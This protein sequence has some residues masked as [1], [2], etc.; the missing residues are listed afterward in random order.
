MTTASDLKSELVGQVPQLDPYAALKFVSRAFRDVADVREWGFLR[1]RDVLQIPASVTT[2]TVSVTQFSDAVTFDGAAAAVLDV[3]NNPPVTRRQLRVGDG[4]AYNI[5]TYTP[6]GTAT[7]DRPYQEDTDASA[8]YTLLRCYY[9]APA[10]FLRFI[11]I[12]DPL[13]Q[14]YV[15]TGPEFTQIWLDRIDPART[16][17]G[18]PWVLCTAQAD[19]ATS[20]LG[21][22]TYE[23]WPWPTTAQALIVNY[24]KRGSDLTKD[25]TLPSALNSQLILARAKY[26]AYEWA[27]AHQGQ[28]KTLQGVSWLQL[29]QVAKTEYDEELRAAIKL[30]QAQNPDTVVSRTRNWGFMCD[31]DWLQRHG[32][33]G[34]ND[35]Y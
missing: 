9:S 1:A 30:D 32:P 22:P 25:S 6:G 5:L 18:E 15:V 31:G 14:K 16:S 24:R 26:R 21:A 3:I 4:P 20:T 29:M 27:L 2:G 19:T 28:H 13:R 17:T 10:D 12:A 8:D 23:M 7:L 33:V 34:W 35:F 11:S